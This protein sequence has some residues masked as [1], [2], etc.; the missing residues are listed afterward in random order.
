MPRKY[1]PLT[2]SG[3]NAGINNGDIDNKIKLNMARMKTYVNKL[4][5]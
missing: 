1:T 4:N 3:K 2:P 5:I